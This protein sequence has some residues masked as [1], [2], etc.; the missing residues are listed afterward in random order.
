MSPRIPIY[1]RQVDI[2]SV[3]VPVPQ[4]PTPPKAAFGGQVVEA[5]AGLGKVMGD[6]GDFLGKYAMKKQDENMN[7]LASQNLMNYKNDMQDWLFN[8][9]N[10]KVLQPDGTK[11]ERPKGIMNRKM[12][13]AVGST[14]ELDNKYKSNRDRY[15]ASIPSAS[16]R[17]ML[18]EKM[19]NHFSSIRNSVISHEVAEDNA[20]RVSIQ[21]GVVDQGITDFYMYQNIPSL[22]KGINDL[23]H[24]SNIQSDVLGETDP[25]LRSLRERDNVLKGL[26]KTIDGAL[27]ADITGAK[28]RFLLEGVKDKLT[29]EDY[30]VLDKD[31]TTK[32]KSIVAD[33]KFAKKQSQIAN[34]AKTISG[35]VNGQ[36]GIND[37]S[38]ISKMVADGELRPEFGKAFIKA[39]EKPID[40]VDY[41][42]E[43]NDEAFVALTTNML[44]AKSPEEMNDVIIDILDGFTGNDLSQKNMVL[45]LQ[46]AL[47]FGS[48]K[49]ASK[50]QDSENAVNRVMDWQ[51]K[52]GTPQGTGLTQFM[53]L[54]REGKDPND[55]ADEVLRNSY[56]SI[57]IDNPIGK[58]E[59]VNQRIR[60]DNEKAIQDKKQLEGEPI[61]Y[62][63]RGLNPF[64]VSSAEASDYGTR[65][66]G[67]EKGMGYFGELKGPDGRIST[68]LSIGVDA[69]DLEGDMVPPEKDDSSDKR[70][71]LSMEGTRTGKEVQIPLLVP[72]LS[73]Q[74]IGYLLGGNLPTQE[75]IRLAINH[76]RDRIKQGKSPF[77]EEGEQ[78]KQEERKTSFELF[79]INPFGSATI[80]KFRKPMPLYSPTGEESDR[81][82]ASNNMIESVSIEEYENYTQKPKEEQIDGGY[83]YLKG[84][85][86]YGWG[87]EGDDTF[88]EG[89]TVKIKLNEFQKDVLKRYNKWTSTP[90]GEQLVNPNSEFNA[91]LEGVA[92]VALIGYMGWQGIK[93]L[94]SAIQV[95]RDPSAIRRLSSNPILSK[96]LNRK[97]TSNE[98]FEL[99]RKSQGSQGTQ[100][101]TIK[102]KEL[103]NAVQALGINRTQALQLARQ[104]QLVT[105]RFGVTDV[106]VVPMNARF[107]I[108]SPDKI[109]NPS[110]WE[111]LIFS[112]GGQLKFSPEQV[113]LKSNLLAVSDFK[114]PNF[115]TGVQALNTLT[116]SGV[117]FEEMEFTKIKD[118]LKT[119]DKFSKGEL[120]DYIE[121]N[122]V[123][124]EPI[125][126]GVERHRVAEGVNP[127]EYYVVDEKGNPV[128]PV[129]SSEANARYYM[130]NAFPHEEPKYS[131]WQL[132]GGENYQETLLTLP[133]GTPESKELFNIEQEIEEIYQSPMGSESLTK[134]LKEL[135]NQRADILDKQGKVSVQEILYKSPHW[136]EPNPLVHHRTNQRTDAQGNKG[137]FVEEIQSDWH[138]EGKSKGYKGIEEIDYEREK[139]SAIPFGQRTDDQQSR[140]DEL[141]KKTA[142]ESQKVPNAPFKNT[143]HELALKDIIRQAVE[144][145]DK[146]VSWISGQQTA[147]RYDL[148]KYIDYIEYAYSPINKYGNLKALDK[149]SNIVINRTVPLIELPGVI[150]KDA[151]ERINKTI[152]INKDKKAPVITLEG[153]DLKVG[154][155][156]AKKFYDEILPQTANKYIKKW[157]GKVEEI[158]VGV[159][160]EDEAGTEYGTTTQKGF[161]IT[162]QMR[163]EVLEVGQPLFG[164]R[165]AG[166]VLSSERG[167]AGAEGELPLPK[168]WEG[169]PEIFDAIEATEGAKLTEKGLSIQ[170]T[171]YQK[172]EQAG[173]VS[174]RGGVFY[175]P[176]QKSPYARYYKTGRIGYGGKQKITKE[177]IFENP[178]IVKGASG[179]KVPERA[180]DRIKGKGAYQKM[181]DDVLANAWSGAGRRPDA[182]SIMNLLEKYGGNED[183]AYDIIE[184]SKEGNQ[185]PYALQEHIVASAIRDAGYDGVLGYS[186]VG[187]KSRLSEVFAVKEE[188]YPSPQ[189]DISE[190]KKAQGIVE[191]EAKLLEEARKYKTAEEFV[192]K[193]YRDKNFTKYVKDVY[194]EFISKKQ[195]ILKSAQSIDSNII[196]VELGG[197]YG[198]LKPTPDSDIDLEFKYNGNPPENLYEELAGVYELGGG[199]ADAGVVKADKQL[200]SIWEKA[201][202]TPPEKPPTKPPTATGG[203]GEEESFIQKTIKD[204]DKKIPSKLKEEKG[205][206]RI[207]GNQE[208]SSEL[209]QAYER[210]KDLWIGEKDVRTTLEIPAE[211][212]QFQTAIKKASKTKDYG[213]VAKEYDQAIQLYIDNKRNPQQVKDLYPTLSAEQK[214]IIDLSNNLPP[215]VKKVADGIAKAY[216]DI[217]LEAL[218]G[219]IIKNVLDNYAGRIWDVE[220]KGSTEKFRKFGKTTRHAKKRVLDT[221]AQGWSLGLDLKVKGAT[222]NLA[223]LKEEIVKT[224]EDKK[225]MQSLAKIKD[226]DGN[227]LITTKHLEGYKKVEHPNFKTWKYAGKAVE[228]ETYGKNIFIDDNGNIFE[229]QEMYAPESQANNLNNIMGVSKLKGIKAIDTIT[230]YN[231]IMKAWILQTSL[232]HHMAFSRSYYLGTNRKTFDEMNLIDAVNDGNRMVDELDPIITQGVRNGLTIGRKQD[233]NE[234]LLKEKTAIGSLLDK[235]NVSKEIKDKMMKLREDQADFLFGVIGSGLKAKAFAIEY[236][237][238]LRKYP[239]EDT[240]VIAKRVANLINDDFG[241]LHLQRMGRNPTVQHI[242]RV[243]ALAPD[244]TESNIRTMV[245]AFKGGEEGKMY[246]DFW[247]GI[248]AKGIGATILANM[249]TAAFDEDDVNG[250]G[251]L[252]RFARNYRYAFKEGKYRW[253]DVD[254]TPIYKALGGTG[255]DR[256]YFSILG[257]FK[258]PLKL[259]VRND[260]AKKDQLTSTFKLGNTTAMKHKSSVVGG[261]FMDYLTGTDY[262]ERR[263]TTIKELVGMDTEKGEYKTTRRGKYKKG[264]PKW[265]KLAGQTVTWDYAKGGAVELEQLPSFI[266][267]KLKGTQP[268]Q[269]QQMMG[270]FAG[271]LDGFIATSNALGLG[272]SKTYGREAQEITPYQ[273]KKTPT[274]DKK[275][276]DGKRYVKESGLWQEVLIKK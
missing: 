193:K 270:Y 254:I 57:N 260:K 210:Q 102:E 72:S 116:R 176:E 2:G 209:E 166:S 232:F 221:I 159:A 99:L 200:I 240:D 201:Q 96:V 214:K 109:G 185:L 51:E 18:A 183:L 36:I 155:E 14:V 205:E 152:E 179:G 172:P 64:S 124:V 194:G 242:F 189:E 53:E 239:N 208:E 191:P 233:W 87:F 19:D 219:G 137:T 3:N 33:N 207:A 73:K 276:S 186:T 133:G 184:Y 197:S 177:L 5:K 111:R 68:E 141:I 34:E 61:T 115:F 245:K 203:E 67:T 23:K 21:K 83:M 222:N 250:E 108:P 8:Q 135:Q 234:D 128:S 275:V 217:G 139:L 110:M 85:S 256:Y 129:Q 175:L 131:T 160:V 52:S 35:F 122:K 273:W 226:V 274:K 272:V 104:G 144:R 106:N 138:R 165:L 170:A 268:I 228:G 113:P 43:G 27:V 39:V 261:I 70:N 161:Y 95:L 238:Q 54:I 50:R 230:K 101:F 265:G 174:I 252:G 10:E 246:R 134:R 251:V 213:T 162:P 142:S 32:S 123:K 249:A 225:F 13:L 48:E 121:Q 60:E 58:D 38:A 167:M 4:V 215:E 29:K 92:G 55:A 132:P 41:D 11:I 255:E 25:T 190:G 62:D 266:L 126:K 91:V 120:L 156:W 66:D 20:N 258:D 262:A 22:E 269:V 264:D 125:V 211:K 78:V 59:D 75:I 112:Q 6:L 44:N 199:F 187:G 88:E 130:R 188:V 164:R 145:G 45:F 77:A 180:Y 178:I 26:K 212:K 103:W 227:P 86:W 150:G 169:K 42:I 173:Q 117:N 140:L 98:W 204:I 253:L 37:T 1:K 118:F 259:S 220:G 7:L 237:N 100:D 236:R 143:W 15:L 182:P 16:H 206:L 82:V 267:N 257:H 158:D 93:G 79:N 84:P 163:K 105:P 119:K 71:E 192:A 149:S 12:G 244:W 195:D 171:R 153:A 81:I 168:D 28:A 157:G 151:A 24:D 247:A 229:R 148:S 147:D 76:A 74:Q 40:E 63:F 136:E 97:V 9:D 216:E 30:D 65:I 181:R 218:E 56:N 46:T 17:A 80:S 223:I 243:L 31:I 235:W 49:S 146:F 196:D 241:G 202:G 271:E 90:I 248:I 231:A 107:G 224:I 154:G 69:S 114:L 263:F 198:K 94:G 47:K 127:G 89:A